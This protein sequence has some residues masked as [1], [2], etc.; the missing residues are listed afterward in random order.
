[1]IPP[2]EVNFLDPVFRKQAPLIELTMTKP[3]QARPSRL[4]KALEAEAHG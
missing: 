3:E 2:I 1:M 4:R